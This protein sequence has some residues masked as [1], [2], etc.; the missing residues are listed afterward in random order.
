MYSLPKPPTL[1]GKSCPG[2]LESDQRMYWSLFLKKFGKDSDYYLEI[3]KK[4]GVFDECDWKSNFKHIIHYSANI[5]DDEDY[6]KA[7]TM[8]EECKEKKNPR[9]ILERD[10]MFLRN[11]PTTISSLGRW[12]KQ[13][14][15]SELD[16]QGLPDELCT[17]KKLE[18]ITI[19]KCALRQLP[20]DIGNLKY[21]TV[22]QVTRCNLQELP[23]SLQECTRLKQLLLSYN[24]L[25]SIPDSVLSLKYLERV[26][27]DANPIT[28]ETWKSNYLP[29]VKHLS[30]N[31]TRINNLPGIITVGLQTLSW[32]SCNLDSLV[33]QEFGPGLISCNL[34]R[35]QLKD[36]PPG[37]L[38]CIKLEYLN[39]S[40]N[41]IKTIPQSLI[42]LAN[43][44]TL[45]L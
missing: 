42:S 40:K 38:R 32:H 9:L 21:L 11:I 29:G 39:L 16:V 8:I 25:A 33:N 18:S 24:C 1:G 19:T 41:N 17:L 5:L 31:Q 3:L 14:Y 37:L 27:L 36:I 6:S 15:L 43:V 28:I 44:K 13:I 4:L 22:L 30:I 7:I 26:N 10:D 45:L 23:E 2:Y 12:L 20:R 35:N 34:A